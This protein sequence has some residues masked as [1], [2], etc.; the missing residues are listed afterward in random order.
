MASIVSKRVMS[1][2]YLAL[3]HCVTDRD[4]MDPTFEQILK[5]KN[6]MTKLQEAA[7]KNLSL[8]DAFSNSMSSVKELLA[9]RFESMKLKDNYV[10]CF[11]S[12]S[13]ER[14]KQFFE[15][16]QQRIHPSISLDNLNDATFSRIDAYQSFKEAHL[17]STS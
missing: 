9:N 13:D 8:K 1:I 2:L 5:A 16:I 14:V 10:Q 4:A 15:V 6:N 3:Q 7:S 17:F 11:P 12:A